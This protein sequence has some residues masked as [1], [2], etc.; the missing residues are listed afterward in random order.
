M[1]IVR[2]TRAAPGGLVRRFRSH[3]PASGAARWPMFGRKGAPAATPTRAELAASAALLPSPL[4][5]IGQ[6]EL[7]LAD[8]PKDVKRAQRLRYE[9]FYKEMSAVADPLARLARR[10]M[11]AYDTV[12]DHLLVLDHSAKRSPAA[13]LFAGLQ[14]FDLR[15][16]DR[17]RLVEAA[18]PPAPAKPNKPRVVGTY[19]LLRQET[20]DRAFG[21]YT[22]GEFGIDELIA[23]HPTR[24]FL[25]LGRSCVLKPFRDKRTVEL[26]WHGIWRYVVAHDV[27]VMIGCASLEG[28]DPERL[29]LPLSY[30]HH[31]HAA[32]PEWR[33]SALADRRSPMDLTPKEAIDPRAA[34]RALPP[35][36]KGYLRLGA[37][38]G[39]GAVV[40]RQFGTTDVLIVLPRSVINP[41]YVAY[42]GADASRHAA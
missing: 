12:C 41:R 30:L 19:R 34:L 27:D 2:A 25:E 5:R 26:L 13:A 24:S 16:L 20:A 15:G 31:F 17:T 21:F 10:D 40:D 29:A 1:A 3:R 36:I 8:R 11:D 6:L 22:A 7:K 37:Y 32:P 14:G 4:G 35:L 9:V 42:Y 33:A 28:A 38:V 18:E 39:D 23:R